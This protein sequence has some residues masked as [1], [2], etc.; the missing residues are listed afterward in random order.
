MTDNSAA[1]VVADRD[2]PPSLCNAC[3]EHPRLGS[4]ARCA[5]CVRAAADVDRQTRAAA[6]ARVMARGHGR[7]IA[8]AERRLWPDGR[9]ESWRRPCEVFKLINNELVAMGCR[10]AE[11][12]LP[13]LTSYKRWWAARRLSIDPSGL[14]DPNRTD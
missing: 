10:K 6:E 5:H 9:I 12:G 4:L 11:G 1:E 13:S 8:E 3:G 2:E 7:K 14:P